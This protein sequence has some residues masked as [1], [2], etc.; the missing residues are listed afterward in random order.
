MPLTTGGLSPPPPLVDS[1][2][3][4]NDSTTEYYPGIMEIYEVHRPI[5]FYVERFLP[6]LWYLIGFPGN[7]MAFIIWIRPKMRPS[8]GCYLAALALGDTCFLALHIIFYLHH[9]LHI[10]LLDSP[11][12]CEGYPVLFLATQYLNPLLVLG[13]TGERYIAI[14]HPFKREK[15]CTTKRAVIV[16]I[17]TIFISL[18][19][20]VIQGYFWH[21][22]GG[23]CSVREA[24]LRGDAKSI[25]SIWSW[26]TELLVF[27]VV[28]IAILVLNILVILETNTIKRSEKKMLCLLKGQKIQ[29]QSGASATTFM[30]LAVSF[31][32]IFTTLPVT[33]LYVL[34]TI[35]PYGDYPMTHEQ[36]A[37]D[38]TWQR[39]LNF[40]TV[41]VIVE[42]VCISHY[43][44]NF[45]IYLSTGHVFRKELTTIF[46]KTFC[47]RMS[48]RIR[49]SE[50]DDLLATYKK[51]STTSNGTERGQNGAVAHV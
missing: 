45:Y 28:P 20:H 40:N 11:V 8:S 14:C 2:G 38:P 41:R 26:I 48:D 32:M 35:F 6:P 50:L 51:P 5:I 3:T 13:F 46:I 27:G 39:H 9:T 25:W 15:W 43:A 10:K 30:L 22:V 1:N 21:M 24:V 23:E 17:L 29:R 33:I 34:N 4:Y 31:Y 18:L 12:L 37:V 49:N 7:I 16:I 42:R 36:I 19:L 44:C 47:K